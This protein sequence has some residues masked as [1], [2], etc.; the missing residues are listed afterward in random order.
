VRLNKSAEIPFPNSFMPNNEAE[1]NLTVIVTVVSGKT[2]LRRCLKALYSQVDFNDSEIIV[3]FDK[4]SN[5]VGDLAA[6]FP[7]VNFY[8]VEDLG[9]ADS[10]NVSAHRH[11]LYDRRRAAGLSSAR[12]RVIA[13]TEDHAI[14]A[15][16]WCERILAA[17]EKSP[18]IVGGA[19][20]NAVDEPL[21]WVWYY[22]DFGR[23]GRPL[24]DGEVEFVSDVNVSYKRETIFS[25][26]DVWSEAYHETSVHWALRERGENLVLDEKIVVYQNRPPLSLTEALRE[27][28]EWGR[29]FAETRASQIGV[30]RRLLFAAGTIFLPPLLLARFV[31]NM[32]RQKR[33]MK[34]MARV[35]PLGLPLLAG[36]SLGEFFGYLKGQPPMPKKEISFA[37]NSKKITAESLTR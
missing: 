35:L 26:R 29:V 19:I 28:I 34:L 31:K 17:H 11:R 10:A 9:L 2:Y 8:F 24:T 14:P 5:D 22:A 32:R 4:W 13:L 36:W 25:I 6:E 33:S 37:R 3:P 1:L 23:Y 16:D 7:G 15:A 18:G 20:E 12:G 27:R 30:G 21:N